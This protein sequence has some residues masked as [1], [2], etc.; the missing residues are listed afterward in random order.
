MQK[1]SRVTQQRR[2]GR[3][4]IYL[5]DEFF[6][7]VDEKILIQYNLFKGTELTE[8]EIAEVTAAEFEQKAYIKGLTI[9]TGRLIAKKQL[10]L[11]LKQGDFPN[12]VIA[13]VIDRLENAGILD[14]QAY[15]QAYVASSI[16]AGKL[17]PK[18]IARKLKT[19]GVDSNIIADAL[20]DYPDDDQ[21]EHIQKQIE[22]LFAKY[23][24]QS[25][26]L[27][28]QKVTQKLIQNGFDQQHFQPL[29]K[30]Y[31]ADFDQDEQQAAEW[32]NL[33]REAQKLADRYSQYTGWDFTR[34]FKTAL[35]RRGFDGDLI[36]QWLSKNNK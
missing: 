12:D 3:Y 4:N 19:F 32:E 28:Q 35:Y 5:D 2:P 30:A 20:A 29:I 16:N 11:K 33:D 36:N 17:G 27:A 18:G 21:E 31:L 25:R 26:M 23:H 14:D 8:A 34:R 10:V 1:I 22:K 13:R 24:H 7:A 6:M 9:A 15:A